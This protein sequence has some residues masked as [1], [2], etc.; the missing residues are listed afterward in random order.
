M[1]AIAYLAKVLL[2][3]FINIQ[4]KGQIGRIRPI[5]FR[6][7]NAHSLF[8]IVDSPYG[9]KFD[10]AIYESYPS[11]LMKVI[12]TLD[13]DFDIQERKE[14]DYNFAIDLVFCSFTL[15]TGLAYFLI[16]LFLTYIA[17]K[18]HRPFT[19]LLI[20]VLLLMASY[21]IFCFWRGTKEFTN[22]FKNR[23]S[24]IEQDQRDKRYLEDE[25]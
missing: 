11:N 4:D 21:V 10:R 15:F 2:S 1:L 25:Q 24:R 6:L 12:S 14:M 7:Y 22:A 20:T 5:L 19:P 13:K 16:D 8:E 23:N 9:K 17:I 18:L 3:F